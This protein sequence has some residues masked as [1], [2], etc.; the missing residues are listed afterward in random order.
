MTGSS[1]DTIARLS[2]RGSRGSRLLQRKLTQLGF[3]FE[4]RASSRIA[5]GAPPVSL[6][7]RSG[8]DRLRPRGRFHRRSP[9]P[10]GRWTAY[11]DVAAAG[12]NE[13][14]A[15]AIGDWLRRRGDEVEHVYRVLRVDGFV[16]DAFRPAGRGIP[17]DA[18]HVRELL[19]REGVSIDSAGR[20]SARQRFTVE[21]WVRLRH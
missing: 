9:V 4:P 8:S 2:G 15:Q 10:Q 16:A 19:R 5:G 18:E 12:G 1:S 7:S 21:D 17:A 3:G 14:G 20:A 11:K 6:L 13:R